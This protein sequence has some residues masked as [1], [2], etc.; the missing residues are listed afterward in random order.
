VD[1]REEYKICGACGTGYTRV[2]PQVTIK[3]EE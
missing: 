2:G 1:R 3:G